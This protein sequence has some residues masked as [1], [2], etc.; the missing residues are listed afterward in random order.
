VLLCPFANHSWGHLVRCLVLARELAALGYR[1]TFA[2]EAAARDRIAA[3]GFPFVEL[4]SM[5]MDRHELATKAGRKRAGDVLAASRACLRATAPDVVVSDMQPIASVACAL[6]AIPS[7]AVLNLELLAHPLGWWLPGLERSLT[8]LD[9]PRWAARRLFG[10]ALIVGDIAGSLGLRDLPPEMTARIAASVREVRWVGPIL[11]PL[12]PRAPRAGVRPR[13]I[14]TLGGGLAHRVADVLAGCADVAADFLVVTPRPMPGL[15]RPG[16]TVVDFLADFATQLAAADVVITHGG[17][18]TL[19]QALALGVPVLVIPVTLEQEI[20]AKRVRE[21]GAVLPA[22]PART[23]AAVGPALAALLA[24]RSRDAARA[25][26]AAALS[27]QDGAREAARVVA[28]Q[29]P[30]S[31]RFFLGVR[32]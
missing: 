13:V 5:T 23:R 25:H 9:V 18:G 14:V 28:A 8:E 24:D 17:H 11:G 1:V 22:D 32:P 31:S 20:N 6:E 21:L 16:L 30:L 2:A 27:A 12:P 3:A 19:V 4:I 29:L 15:E 26:Y 7:V 10:D